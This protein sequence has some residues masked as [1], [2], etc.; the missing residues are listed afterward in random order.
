MG[1]PV[2][3]A[4]DRRSEILDTAQM[5]FYTKGYEKTAVRDIID[6][7]GIAK[8]TF[9]HHFNSKAELL[10]ALITRL[11]DQS[12][13]LLDPILADEN[14]T[15]LEKLHSFFGQVS[16][17]KIENESL[18]RTLLPIW[19]QEDNTLMREKMTLVSQEKMT[20]LFSQI[21]QQGIREGVFQAVYPAEIGGIVLQSLFAMGDTLARLLLSTKERPAWETIQ[22][23]IDAYNDALARLLGAESGAIH[24]FNLD[25][26]QH[27]FDNN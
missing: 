5:L 2:K 19:Y 8:G 10:D 21:V 14:L 7:V 26:F 22:V 13:L 16:N 17:L 15:A 3:S 27:W 11:L 24:L 4:D 1:Q 12:M 18:M 25:P 20:P 6:E 9:Y 23:K